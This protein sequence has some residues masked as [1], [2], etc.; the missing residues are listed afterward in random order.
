MHGT[1]EGYDV[2]VLGG[3]PAGC[4]LAARLS[5][6]PGRSV[7]LVEAG[8]D[9]GSYRGGR[10]PSELLDARVIPD[11]H[12]WEPRGPRHF[13]R[14]RVIG[15]CSCHNGCWAVRGAPSDYDDWRPI[16]V[17]FDAI[18]P[19]LQRAETTLLVRD[20]VDP[21]PLSHTAE[22]IA[23]AGDIGLS[24][25]RDVN[26][27]AG[28]GAGLV[29]LNAVDGVRWNAAFGYLDPARE[30]PNLHVLPDTLV[31]RLAVRGDRVTRVHAVHRGRGVELAA[32]NVVL[33]A[34]A[35][36]S[37][38]ILLRSGVGPEGDLRRLGIGVTAP[39]PGVGANLVD[40]PGVNLRFRGS[41]RLVAA[42]EDETMT[43]P[44]A[45]AHALVKARS[46]RCP[47]GAWD[48]HLVPSARLTEPAAVGRFG[49]A[50]LT[51]GVFGMAPRSRGRISL[52]SRDPAAPPVIEL[53]LL[54]DPRG[55]DEEMLCQGVELA[56]R[57]MGAA[58]MQAL[59]NGE[60]DP[61]PSARR[62]DRWIAR[63]AV[64]YWHSTGS[65]AMGPP[66]DGSAVAGADGRV[67]D[68]G[69]LFVVDA[70]AMPYPPRANIH[71]TVVALAELLA[72][73]IRGQV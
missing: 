44:D 68:L 66:D 20:A 18:E 50:R 49:P 26:A 32:T 63:A 65:C 13:A 61:G 5:E 9:Y 46:D 72:D 22:F 24:T 52:T 43:R 1:R 55:H 51:M 4:V 12:D 15:G 36:G 37:P 53:G 7:A 6:D 64:G 58:P 29:P 28:A 11:T 39:L 23:A 40:H 34:G 73:R 48:L 14:A 17:G 25:R 62:D 3:G 38:G 69:N 30:R 67:R 27:V 2:A 8:P 31:D 41:E 47:D 45:A 10:W 54:S 70:S 42:L 16:G 59:V 57:M 60:V 33:A 19:Y 71:L 21:V 56:R 35:F